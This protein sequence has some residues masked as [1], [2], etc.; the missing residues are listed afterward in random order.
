MLPLEKC[1]FLNRLQPKEFKDGEDFVMEIRG[2]GNA[3]GR[4]TV[5]KLPL[6]VRVQVE[7]NRIVL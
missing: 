1:S 6:D 2:E 7:L 3:L 4:M 5:S